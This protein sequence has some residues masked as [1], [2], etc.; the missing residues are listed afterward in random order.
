MNNDSNFRFS[1][2]HPTPLGKTLEQF[3]HHL[4]APPVRTLSNLSREWPEVV[5]PTLAQHSKPTDVI[6]G[7]LSI[8]CDD[9][10]WASQLNWM[11]HQIKQR[12]AAI[13]DGLEVSR[14]QVR[15]RA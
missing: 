13:F 1:G 3:L 4:G 14:V 12:C 7:V 15:V 11:D 5:G 9:A 6:D 10:S 2:W 8:I